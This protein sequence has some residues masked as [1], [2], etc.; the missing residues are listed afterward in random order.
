[1]FRA[2]RV[3]LTAGLCLS[4]VAASV[5]SAGCAKDKAAV[6]PPPGDS[7]T[8]VTPPPVVTI[9]VQPKAVSFSDT[10]GTSNPAAA[11]INVTNTGT[12]MARHV[13]VGTITYSAGATGWLTFAVN[14]DSAPTTLNLQP[15]MIG[16]A[17][18]VYTATVPI[19]ADSATNGPQNVTVSFTLAATP[20]QPP[21]PPPSDPPPAPIP[22]VTVLAMGNIAK[23]G[24]T[25]SANSA[26]VVRTTPFDYLFV[27]GDNVYPSNPATL[28]DYTNCY[29]PLLGAFKAKTFAAVGNRDQDSAG[30]SAGAD[31][32]FGPAAVGPAGKNYYSFNVGTGAA[33]WHIVVLNVISGGPTVGVPYGNSS[34]QL[35]W[36]QADL[37]ANASAKCTLVFYHDPMWLSSSTTSPTD[38][39]AGHRRQP[40]RGLWNAMYSANVDLV[41]G[42]GDHIYER[43]APMRYD[44]D[45]QGPEFAADSV[46]GIVQISAGLGG[47]GPGTTPAV[48]ER[49][50]LSRYRSGGNGVLKL[51]LGDGVYTWQF[52]NGNGSNVQDWGSGTCH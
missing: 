24:G 46:R 13:A 5:F 34:A 26:A 14:G 52:L 7:D 3:H 28:A 10:L 6:T 29:D 36:F 31:A 41:L 15:S 35:P 2:L 20:P 49:H 32:Y 30:I 22:G 8:T 39:N 33:M 47:D 42:G 44:S 9:D 27:M 23:C 17:P 12:G 19:T 4:M 11:T 16:L 40:Q 18:G 38:H 43:F 51:V 48:T 25:L 21:D 37:A 1:M 50:P 45:L